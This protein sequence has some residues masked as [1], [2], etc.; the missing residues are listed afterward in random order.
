VFLT[1]FT[2]GLQ[3][4]VQKMNYR[5]DLARIE[6]I[7]RRAKRAAWGT[8][9]IPLTG[10]RKIRVGLGEEYDEDGFVDASR[11]IE[12]VVEGQDVYIVSPPVL[13][14]LYCSEEIHTLAR[15]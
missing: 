3:L 15:R 9:M 7:T 14:W 1:I 10:Q 4:L 5:K 11:S 2:S 12:M 8:K 6:L 13:S